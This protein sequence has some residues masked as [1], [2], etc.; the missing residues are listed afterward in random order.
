MADKCWKMTFT[1]SKWMNILTKDQN[2][3][4]FFY[5]NSLNP[6]LFD[7][8]ETFEMIAEEQ[9]LAYTPPQKK[10][11]KAVTTNVQDYNA[12][13][14]ITDSNGL[15]KSIQKSNDSSRLKQAQPITNANTG[16][17]ILRPVI[18][19][20]T[21]K[22]DQKPEEPEVEIEGQIDFLYRLWGKNDGKPV[23]NTTEK[24][25]FTKLMKKQSAEV[26]RALEVK[27]VDSAY[28]INHKRGDKM[29][30]SYNYIIRMSD[31]RFVLKNQ[32]KPPT[33]PLPQVPE[34]A[35]ARLTMQ[36]SSEIPM[37]YRI[38]SQGPMARKEVS[39]QVIQFKPENV[40]RHH[41][42]HHQ[43]QDIEE[44]RNRVLRKA[45]TGTFSR[46]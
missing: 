8:Q 24:V 38:V 3:K 19:Q 40:G 2:V 11:T 42:S 17:P 7:H 13:E 15:T 27:N 14:E 44:K 31:S 33:P 25:K 46:K 30:K 32:A 23:I 45:Q 22:I 39:T 5:R 12:K 4:K 35:P 10:L 18:L 20:K 16:A 34:I 21:P 43:Q 29:T 26:S 9:K 41:C 28:K 36:M 1:G 37:Y 6:N